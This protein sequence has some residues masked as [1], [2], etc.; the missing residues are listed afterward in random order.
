MVFKWGNMWIKL[1]SAW[2]FLTLVPTS[3]IVPLNDLAVEHRMY[4][5]MSLGL[6]LIA[7]W[8]I[9]NFNRINQVRSFIFI[10]FV[11]VFV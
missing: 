10:L 6:C 8:I 4:L 11:V 5:P 3:T 9:K 1:G 2:F 7:G